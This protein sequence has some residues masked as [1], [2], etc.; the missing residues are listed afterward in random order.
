ME[1]PGGAST[2]LCWVLTREAGVFSATAPQVAASV[3][4]PCQRQG[5]KAV[6]ALHRKG[7]PGMLHAGPSA[8]VATRSLAAASF[9]ESQKAAL[10]QELSMAKGPEQPV[11]L[12]VTP[13]RRKL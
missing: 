6:R 12:P 13:V 7:F 2:L 9:R 3:A 8:Q 11:V 1:K 5:R 4:A 10:P